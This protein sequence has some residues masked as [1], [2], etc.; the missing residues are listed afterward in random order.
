MQILRPG[1][2]PK[3]AILSILVVV[4]FGLVGWRTM[5][6]VRGTAPAANDG[7]TGAA[8]ALVKIPGGPKV[9]T[10]APEKAIVVTPSSEPPKIDPFKKIA[11]PRI[12]PSMS[13]RSRINLGD[14][15]MDP[16]QG[17]IE[18]LPPARSD[19]QT[20]APADPSPLTIT[21][22]GVLTGGKG[23]AIIRLGKD[24]LIVKVGESFGAAFR[25]ISVSDTEI[26]VQQGKK[27]QTYPVKWG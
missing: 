25:L 7:S 5:A 18:S 23:V 6:S 20:V 10:P 11:T 16:L 2:G 19:T 9:D 1:D 3:A 12:H 26:V 8:D 15:P 21:V 14:M 13:G 27:L 24:T 17:D 22:Q 4:M